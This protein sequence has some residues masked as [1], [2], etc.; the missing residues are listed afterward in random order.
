MKFSKKAVETCEAL[1]KNFS[2]EEI[3]QNNQYVFD[4]VKILCIS[5]YNIG[6][7]YVRL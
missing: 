1:L 4:L 2:E 3:N 7:F 5:L 6:F